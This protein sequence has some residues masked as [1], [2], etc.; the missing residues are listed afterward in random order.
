MIM[1]RFGCL[2]SKSFLALALC[3]LFVASE[4]AMAQRSAGGRGGAGGR[5]RPQPKQTGQGNKKPDPVS[6]DTPGVYRGQISKYEPVSDEKDDELV[7]VLTLK[8]LDKG[9]KTLKVQMRRTEN[10]RIQIGGHSIDVESCADLLSKGLCCSANWDW[11]P[12]ATDKGKPTVRELRSLTLDTIMVSGVIE[13]VEGEYITI[14]ARPKDNS[15][16][17]DA[18]AKEST[19]PQR[20]NESKAKLAVQKKLRLKIVEEV[21]DFR[22]AASQSLDLGDFAV[23]QQIEAVVVY[24]KKQGILVELRSLTAAEPKE[25]DQAGPRR[26]EQGGGGGPR[27]RGRGGPVPRGGSRG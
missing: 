10:F 17:P 22:D 25:G 3:L 2:K 9:A 16:W 15:D 19:T 6:P 14:K 13:E 5:G 24:G 12:K 11:L 23:E 7:G 21:S 20:G 4:E 1:P 8:S 18:V 26:P 27:P